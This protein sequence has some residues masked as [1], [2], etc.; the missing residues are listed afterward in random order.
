[1][2]QIISNFGM[3]NKLF[4]FQRRNIKNVNQG[5]LQNEIKCTMIV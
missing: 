5:D 1:M 2:Q 3:I 4:S